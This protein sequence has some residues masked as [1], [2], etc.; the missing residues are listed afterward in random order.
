MKHLLLLS[1]LFFLGCFSETGSPVSGGKAQSSS[2]TSSE[3]SSENEVPESSSTSSDSQSSEQPESISSDEPTESSKAQSSESG[4]TDG[5]LIKGTI[6]ASKASVDGYHLYIQDRIDDTWVNKRDYI[7][8]GVCW[9]PVD[10]GTD[11]QNTNYSGRVD[12]DAALMETANINTVRLYGHLPTNNSGKAILNTLF[13]HGIRVIMVV[14]WGGLSAKDYRETIEYFKDHPG[15]LAWQ[16]GNELNY[17][18]FYYFNNDFNAAMAYAKE[19]LTVTADADPNHPSILGWGHPTSNDYKNNFPDLS[20]D[21]LAGQVYTGDSFNDLFKDHKL[22]SDKPFF[23]SEYGADSYNHNKNG[24]DYDSQAH[25]VT[26]LTKEIRDNLA[27]NDSNT[28]TT[29]G[30]TLFSWND[31]WWKAGDWG[32]QDSEGTVLGGA[33]PYPDNT[34]DEDYWGIVTI[35]RSKKDAFDALK[36]VYDSY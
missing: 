13:D 35:D 16:V 9:A 15:I 22:R 36:E 14:S 33:G 12:E 20:F 19:M 32:R 31:E 26:K 7:I 8:K 23:I 27:A 25:A 21:I 29:I 18:A 24:E 2:D 3:Q 4:H 10:K 11:N 28:G 34:F 17:N 5:P 1:I 6:T 30:G